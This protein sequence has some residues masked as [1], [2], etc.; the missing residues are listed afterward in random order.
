[1][2]LILKN[3][4][5]WIIDMLQIC[6][7]FYAFNFLSA[8]Y[9]RNL[10]KPHLTYKSKIMKKQF[11]FAAIAITLCSFNACK[12]S[13]TATPAINSLAAIN[14]SWYVTTW[15][16]VANNNF[17]YKIDQSLKTSVVQSI[18]TQPFGY[19]VGETILSNITAT[20]NA[21][22]FT[23]DAIFH[24][25]NNNGSTASTTGTLTLQTSGTQLL[26][27]LAAAQG[28]QPNDW[29]YLKQ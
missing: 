7:H 11:Y 12:K 10:L 9:T 25:G 22:V 26:V 24:Y 13:S 6:S 21:S 15:G 28:V 3:L 23:C 27:H 5:K 4:S 2:L 14:A 18:G 20:A 29:T 17:V 1:M 16:G 8:E 19:A